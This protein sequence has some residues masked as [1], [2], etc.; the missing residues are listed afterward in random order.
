MVTKYTS[1]NDVVD[2]KYRAVFIGTHV[3]RIPWPVIRDIKWAKKSGW[4]MIPTVKS[5]MHNAPTQT[6]DVVWSVGVLYI[7]KMQTAF[8][9]IANKVGRILM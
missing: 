4:T 5:L 8:P 2:I 9:A 3:R 7:T 6:F 1:K